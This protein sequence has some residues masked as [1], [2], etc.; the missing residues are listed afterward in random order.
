LNINSIAKARDVLKFMLANLTD[1]LPVDVEP[2]MV[3]RYLHRE[4]E[5]SFTDAIGYQI[6]QRNGLRFITGDVA[7]KGFQNVEFM[8]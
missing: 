8:K 7:F 3:F 1:T 4:K 2:A 6:S 5:F